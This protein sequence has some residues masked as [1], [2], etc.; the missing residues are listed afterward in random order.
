MLKKQDVYLIAMLGSDEGVVMDTKLV[1]EKAKK[2]FGAGGLLCAESVLTSVSDEAGV[3]SPLIPRIATG[4]CGGIARTRGMCGAVT[5]GIMALGILYGRDNAE[6]SYETVYEK[7]QQF[8]QAFEAEYK[9]TNCFELTGYDLGKEEE[10]KAFFEK[11]MI[12]KCRQ[13]TGRAASLVAELISGK[14][15]NE[16]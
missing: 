9:S 1:E 11:G 16:G 8:L 7:V 10:R 6:Q 15:D 14:E 4:F 12:E 5:G 3:I 13:F 2:M